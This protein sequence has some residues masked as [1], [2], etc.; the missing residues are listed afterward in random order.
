MKGEQKA[1][2][3]KKV[4]KRYKN[5]YDFAKFIA[6][7]TFGNAIKIG[8]ITMYT[9]NQ[10]AESIEEFKNKA[11]RSKPNMK[12]QKQHIINSAIAL[13]KGREKVYKAF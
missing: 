6:I 10:L 12:T 11:R 7:C 8:I 13:L 9:P 2:K 4:Y 3:R 5:T 1:D